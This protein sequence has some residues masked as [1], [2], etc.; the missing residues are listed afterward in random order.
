MP[1]LRSTYD[2]RLIYKTSMAPRI[3]SHKAPCSCFPRKVSLQLLSEQSVGDVG[4]TQLDWKRVPQ[5][6]GEVPRL[7]KFCRH[8]YWVLAAARKWKRQLSAESAECCRTRDGS[9]RP[10]REAPARTVTGEP[11]MPLWTWRALG[12]IANEDYETVGIPPLM[13]RKTL[14]IL[15]GGR[16]GGVDRSWRRR[17]ITGV[18]KGRASDKNLTSY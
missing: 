16:G 18:D 1:M 8:N 15:D 7:Q 2:G 17:G 4:M 10:S 14:G 12:R 5:A 3:R 6:R 9:R 13:S 11:G